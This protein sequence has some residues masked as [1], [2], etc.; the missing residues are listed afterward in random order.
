MTRVAFSLRCSAGAVL[1]IL[2]VSTQAAAAAQRPAPPPNL[3]GL[4]ARYLSK[5]A[6]PA[7][8]AVVTI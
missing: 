7:S 4:W 2:V 6:E 3:N 5:P 1:A 8:T